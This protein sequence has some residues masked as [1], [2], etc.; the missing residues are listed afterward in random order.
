MKDIDFIAEP[1]QIAAPEIS[2]SCQLRS[3]NLWY[4]E[5]TRVVFD[6]ALDLF[7]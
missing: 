6:L 5:K 1:E 4:L 2:Y 3:L 7:S